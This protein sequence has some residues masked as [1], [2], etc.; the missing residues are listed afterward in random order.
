MSFYGL[1][2][3]LCAFY[4]LFLHQNTLNHI[5]L[6]KL[7]Q[8]FEKSTNNTLA[9]SRFSVFIIP[10]PTGLLPFWELFLLPQA[11]FP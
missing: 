7:F 2:T 5:H 3:H 1:E 4:W 9:N 10:K 8:Q 11:N 6:D